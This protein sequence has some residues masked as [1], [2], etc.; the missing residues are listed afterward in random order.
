MDGAPWLLASHHH[1]GLACKCAPAGSEHR[2]HGLDDEGR[3]QTHDVAGG[4]ARLGY[5]V[6]VEML[7]LA[8][9][10]KR[11]D[12]GLSSGGDAVITNSVLA[13]L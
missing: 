2:R 13:A 12:L 10:V 6:A 3:G 1:R 9:S 11:P 4:Q 7:I 5:K 8:S